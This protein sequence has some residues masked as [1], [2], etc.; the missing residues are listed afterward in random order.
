MAETLVCIR[1]LQK[2]TAFPIP[3][4]PSAVRYIVIYI[5]GVQ[6]LVT[7]FCAVVHPSG[8]SRQIRIVPDIK[9]HLLFPCHENV[10]YADILVN[11]KPVNI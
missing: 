7:L 3:V 8:T 10:M 6:I 9:I 2:I 4:N 11:R 1:S 5:V